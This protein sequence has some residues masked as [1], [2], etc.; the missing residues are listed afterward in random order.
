MTSQRDRI[1]SL[2]SRMEELEATIRGLTEELVDANQRI[3]ELEQAQE[4]ADADSKSESESESAQDEE[5]KS[6]ESKDDTEEEESSGLGDDI[7]VA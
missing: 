3:R 6:D 4:T 2:E 1:G 5:A 7:I